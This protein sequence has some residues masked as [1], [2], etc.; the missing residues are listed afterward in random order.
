MGT[1]TSFDLS[2]RQNY[3]TLTDSN[4]LI[5]ISKIAEYLSIYNYS[6][7]NC[8]KAGTL[9]PVMPYPSYNSTT[10]ILTINNTVVNPGNLNCPNLRGNQ[11]T[12]TTEVYLI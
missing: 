3:T 11:L 5:R 9:Y 2:N 6:G 12:Y 8:I 10:G 1:G 7:S 4:F